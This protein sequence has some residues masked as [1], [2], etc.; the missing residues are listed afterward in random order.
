MIDPEKEEVFSTT[1]SLAGDQGEAGV[2]PCLRSLFPDYAVAVLNDTACC[3]YAEKIY[4]GIR[5]KDYAFIRFSRGIAHP[6]SYRISFSDRPVR[7]IPN[8][9]ISAFPLK[10]LPVPAA[11]GAAWR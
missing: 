6:C 3:A 11:A 10:A 8:S 9:D 7:L 1:F 2:I 4:T 5:E